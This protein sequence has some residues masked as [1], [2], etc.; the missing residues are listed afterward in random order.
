MKT[1]MEAASLMMWHAAWQLAQSGDALGAVSMAKLFGSETYVKLANMGM[2]VMGAFGYSM[3]YDMQRH[4]RDARSVT[5][6]AG[7]SQMQRNLIAHLLKTD[8]M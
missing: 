5:I 2:Q 8:R 1:E 7:T 6:G 3:E 4:Y